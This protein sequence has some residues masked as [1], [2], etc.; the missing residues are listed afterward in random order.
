MNETSDFILFL[1]RFHPLVVHLPIGI[2]MFAFLLEIVA[3]KEKFESLNTA[4]PFALLLGFLSALIACVLG[5]MLSLSGDYDAAMLDSHFWFG[6]FTTFLVLLAWLVRTDILKISKSHKVKANISALT[7][8]VILVSV[9][10]HYGGNL[11]HGSDYLTK[12]APFGQTEKKELVAVT[13]I[14]DAQI[15]GH[16]VQPILESKCTSCHNESKKKGGLSLADSLAIFQGGKSGQVLVPG[17]ALKSEMIKRVLLQPH[18]DDFMPPEGK[19]ALTEEEIAIISYWIDSSQA[20]FKTTIGTVETPENVLGFAAAYLG[21]SAE[22]HATGGAMPT[23]SKVDENLIKDLI[24]EG[25]RVSELAFDS[26]LYEVVLPAKTVTES[27]PKTMDEKLEK[28]LKIKDNVIWLNL[29]DNQITDA[30]LQTVSQ[31]KNLQKLNLNNNAI[32]DAGISK[33]EN[34]Q[35]IKSINLYS[36][37]IT[38]ASLAYLS[39]MKNLKNVYVWK[40]ALK[41]ED[42]AALDE[43]TKQNLHVVFGI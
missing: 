10:G 6:V 7:L 22:E 21:L 37:K 41:P 14:E 42:M 27:N 1:G 11:T 29:E 35:S 13:K 17:S 4:V 3:R 28:L 2:L 8:I 20:G 25:F 43:E 33:L 5:Y 39:K 38:K 34:N 30:Q 9:T 32:T 23:V 40:T 31:F 18:H 16:L 26:N 19:T 24:S 36:T 12:Y 15:Y